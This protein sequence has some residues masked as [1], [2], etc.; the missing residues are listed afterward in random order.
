MDAT[1]EIIGGKWKSLIICLLMSGTKRTSEFQRSIHGISQ[2]VL[3]QQL[4]EL[5]RDGLVERFVYQQMP[6]KVEY[7][8]TEYG[9]TANKIVDVMC[10][11][12]KENIKIRQERGEEILLED[13][14]PEN[15]D[16][17]RHSF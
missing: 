11:W 7:S 17:S 15:V 3:I 8:L 1:L 14:S 4:R 5:E 10:S 9:V 2:K 16:G 13:K 6:P 12:G